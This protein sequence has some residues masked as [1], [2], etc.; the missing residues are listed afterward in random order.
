M[1][2]FLP[3]LFFTGLL[4]GQDLNHEQENIYNRMKIRIVTERE[5]KSGLISANEKI[6]YDIYQGYEE[7]TPEKLVLE[8]GDEEYYQIIKQKRIAISNNRKPLWCFIGGALLLLVQDEGGR[9]VDPVR[10]PS[11]G[12][13][14]SSLYYRL[15]VKN[16]LE[17]SITFLSLPQAIDMSNMYNQRL[18]KEIKEEK[19]KA[20]DSTNPHPKG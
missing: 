20:S 10:A 11:I 9:V 6:D 17:K 19:W 4:F 13:I 14:L 1:K 18:L 3:I 7:I 16:Q 15:K 8:F 12:L 2:R 5:L